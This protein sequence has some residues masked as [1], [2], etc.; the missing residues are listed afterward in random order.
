MANLLPGENLLRTAA[1]VWVP[2][3]GPP[4]NG[5]LTLTNQ[6]LLFEGPLPW[7]GGGPR[8]PMMM[9]PRRP[10]MRPGMGPRPAMAP[11]LLRIPLWRCR[12]ASAANGP[13]GPGLTVVLLQRQLFF[14]VSDAEAFAAAITQARALAPPAPP[15]AL[16]GPPGGAARA[17]M[18]RCE[19]CGQ[20]SAATAT[21]CEHCGAPF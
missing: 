14:R 2:L 13:D 15:G 19:Y 7:G 9:G 17:A 8:R 10:M 4:R 12:S 16:A 21:T 6:A 5:T 20:L 1:V 3:Q 11:G 18:P